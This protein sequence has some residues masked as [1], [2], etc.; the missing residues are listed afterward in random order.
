MR[1]LTE[2]ELIEINRQ[3]IDFAGEGIIGVADEKGL[4]SIVAAPQQ[5]FFGREAYPNIWL[6]AAYYLQKITKK[7]V[8]LDGNKRTALEA[9]KVFLLLNGVRVKF[10]GIE[11]GQMVLDVTTAPDSQAVMLKIAHY[12]QTHQIK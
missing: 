8:F 10:E 7:H 4:Q 11:A 1:Y 6:K 9:A 12:F 2:A 5:I 3:V